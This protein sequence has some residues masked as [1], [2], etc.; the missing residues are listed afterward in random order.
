MSAMRRGLA[1]GPVGLDG[2]Q[3][4]PAGADAARGP[5]PTSPSPRAGRARSAAR[6]VPGRRRPGGL[7]RLLAEFSVP[8]CCATSSCPT[9]ATSATAG[10]RT[11]SV[12]RPGALR[13]GISAAGCS[14]WRA[15]GTRGVGPRASGLP[16]D[17]H[18]TS[19]D[20]LRAR[21]ARARLAH[22]RP[23]HR[24][25]HRH[26]ARHRRRPRPGRSSWSPPSARGRWGRRS[27]RSSSSLG[28]SMVAL[29]GRGA[30][31]R[32]GPAGGRAPAAGRAH[33]RRS[34]DRRGAL[35]AG[36]RIP[37]LPAGVA[38][39]SIGGAGG[40][41]DEFLNTTINGL[42]SGASTRSGPSAC[43]WSTAS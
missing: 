10:R 1:P 16:P 41:V 18:T 42:A 4:G 3:D 35:I 17:E 34:E 37:C 32:A 30:T 13:D 24:T 15:A 26:P 38:F 28:S 11:R 20:R 25:R 29:A 9:C 23:R 43:R 12:G 6:V 22:H 5:T 33:R 27:A 21:A 7:D 19:A 14:A 36:G 39:R 2:G 40:R 31:R 8:R